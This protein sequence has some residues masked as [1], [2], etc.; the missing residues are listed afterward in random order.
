MRSSVAF[1]AGVGLRAPHHREFLQQRPKLNWL[2]V[3]TENYFQPGGW[4]RHVLFALRSDYAISLHG[5][6]LG[7][8]SARGL[9][10]KHLRRV[11]ALAHDL[12]PALVSEHLSWGAVP[13]RHLN[14]LLPLPLS[15]AS[16]DLLCD[17]VNQVQECLQRQ[18]LLENVSTYLRFR[19]DA[20]RE[21]DFLLALAKRTGCRIL[22][23]VNNL[24]VNQINH[25]ESA[26]EAM[27]TIAAHS[28]H[29]V[30]EIHLAG[31][32]R[33][34]DVAIDNH[35]SCVS[36]AV[37]DLY[38]AALE[39]F[40][41]VPTLIEWD[42]D[43]PPLPVLLDEAAKAEV[44]L[45]SARP[46]E[47]V[48]AAGA[49]PHPLPLPAEIAAIQTAFA[50]GLAAPSVPELDCFV[51]PFDQTTRRFAR[52]RGNQIATWENVLA[53]AY[54]VIRALVGEEFFA[55]MAQPYN[56][57][58]PSKSGDLNEMGAAFPEFLAQ[59]PHV[60]Q[61]PYFPDVARL[62]WAIHLAYYAAEA[63]DPLDA[64][65][66]ATWSPEQIEAAC[67]LLNPA[68]RLFRSSWAVVDVWQAHQA[69][70][71]ELPERLNAETYTLVC[72]PDWKPH[73][74]SISPSAYA[75]LSAL[76]AGATFGAAL[77]AAFQ[78]D[79]S[80]DV[81]TNLRQWVEMKLLSNPNPATRL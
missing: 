48:T 67:F 77:D 50:N 24:Y 69:E 73:V 34:D 42:T 10:I 29:V 44:Y 56:Y 6:G 41:A 61:Y 28:I 17:R 40:G 80:F 76:A 30:G 38:R 58:H 66:L 35:G 78:A 53:G 2:E 25:G 63:P 18:I 59:F 3:H 81:M 26:L 19:V 43:I 71:V 8:G 27:A 9:D 74:L 32:L 13:D 68:C 20:M 7:L 11:Q 16:L 62:E 75:A 46:A 51:G 64:H 57:A 47:C 1:G 31:H 14:D 55:A 70:P 49:A 12:E 23:D 15:Q 21:S 72:R 79:E 52:Y 60:A 22:L 37:W 45:L 65:Q 54:P 33:A 5:V 39:H 36:D 4:D